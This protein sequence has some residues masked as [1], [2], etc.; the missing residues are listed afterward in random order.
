MTSRRH[1]QK[2]RRRKR[3]SLERGEKVTR[4]WGKRPQ[5]ERSKNFLTKKPEKEGRSLD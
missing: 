5:N 4:T 3:R 1:V 2:E